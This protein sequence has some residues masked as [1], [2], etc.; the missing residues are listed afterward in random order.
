[1]ES[2]AADDIS[3]ASTSS[4]R[5]VAGQPGPCSPN[6]PKREL[7]RPCRSASTALPHRAAYI[8]PAAWRSHHGL[9][10]GCLVWQRPF[11][12]SGLTIVGHY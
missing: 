1:V 2:Q 5:G 4:Y 12:S 10:A 6:L 11:R 7:P 9:L 3:R 8:V